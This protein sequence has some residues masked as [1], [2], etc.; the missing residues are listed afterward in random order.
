MFFKR[1]DRYKVIKSYM[2]VFNTEAGKEVLEDMMKTF[3]VLNS[4][5]STDALEMAYREGERSV[6]LR[7]LK[8]INTDPSELLR[9]FQEARGTIE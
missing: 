6:V 1:K 7:I 9:M 8:T 5:H 2:E 4:T 3:H